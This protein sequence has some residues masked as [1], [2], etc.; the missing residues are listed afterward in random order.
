MDLSS[1]K[2]E[3]KEDIDKLDYLNYFIVDRISRN[4]DSP[5]FK[6]S[7]IQCDSEMRNPSF[8]STLNQISTYSIEKI[9]PKFDNNNY[10][11]NEESQNKISSSVINH[12]KKSKH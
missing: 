4:Y 3:K 6:N 2:N 9:K 1:Y 11:S 10:L 8:D 12:K 7:R 5:R